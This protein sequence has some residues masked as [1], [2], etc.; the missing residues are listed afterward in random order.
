[1]FYLYNHHYLTLSIKLNT[2]IRWIEK[3]YRNNNFR[4]DIKLLDVANVD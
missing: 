1:M 3:V 4:V 2:C